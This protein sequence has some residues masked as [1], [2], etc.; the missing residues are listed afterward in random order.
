MCADTMEKKKEAE[1]IGRM[2][3]EEG[4]SFLRMFM[5]NKLLSS[6]HDQGRLLG[7][8]FVLM[9]ETKEQTTTGHY[10]YTWV[11]ASPCVDSS[12]IPGMKFLFV[13]RRAPPPVVP[14]PME[15]IC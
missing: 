10:V 1:E 9:K 6:S 12:S 15:R 11:V 7:W 14:R 2:D 3:K 8:M 4:R 5:P 13:A